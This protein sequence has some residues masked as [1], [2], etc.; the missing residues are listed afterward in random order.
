MNKWNTWSW[1]HWHCISTE[2]KYNVVITAV[3]SSCGGNWDDLSEY[4]AQAGWL[5]ELLSAFK[6]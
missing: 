3:T 5:K 2:Q 1:C 4:T 6:F